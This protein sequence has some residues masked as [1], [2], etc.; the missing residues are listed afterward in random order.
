[1]WEE[2]ELTIDG[3]G[4]DAVSKYL[5]IHLKKEDVINEGFEELIYTKEIK[6]RKAKVTSTK[7]CSSNAG[8]LHL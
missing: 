8:L 5:G 6:P 3:I 2:S 4:N 1:M 7:K